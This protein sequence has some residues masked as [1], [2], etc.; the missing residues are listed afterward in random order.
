M[1]AGH[2]SV[3]T[4]RH[5]VDVDAPSFADPRSVDGERVDGGREELL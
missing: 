5:S 3:L 4:P 1:N 2:V